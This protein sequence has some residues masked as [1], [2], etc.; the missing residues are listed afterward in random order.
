VSTDALTFDPAA[1]ADASSKGDGAAT[2]RL[3]VLT[4][5]GLWVPQSWSEALRLLDLSAAQG[6]GPA[7]DDRTALTA[8]ADLG[9]WLTPPSPQPLMSGPAILTVPGFLPPAL[10]DWLIDQVRDTTHP[11]L[12]YNPDTGEGLRDDIRTNSASQIGL[13]RMTVTTALIRERIARV[14]GLPVPGLEWT[15]ILHYGPGQT[16]DWHV[17]WLNPDEPGHAPDLA[18]RGQR[19]ATLLVYLNDD[20]EGGETAFEAGGLRHR[21]GKGDALMWA[22]TLPS[23]GIDPRTLHAGLPPTTGEKWVLSQW[24]RGRAPTG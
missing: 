1:L 10:C 11:A 7:T 16:F 2:H 17:D 15:Q 6:H 9:Q 5:M 8:L 14:A 19:I 20:Y 21:G 13:E 24:L 4:G 23:G 22:N 12:V 3:A 18:A